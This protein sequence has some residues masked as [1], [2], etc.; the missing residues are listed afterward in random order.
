MI[1]NEANT[2]WTLQNC[3]L[4]EKVYDNSVFWTNHTLD[5]IGLDSLIWGTANRGPWPPNT[6]V[7]EQKACTATFMYDLW[8]DHTKGYEKWF[9]A[10]EHDTV[11]SVCRLLWEAEHRPLLPLFHQVVEALPSYLSHVWDFPCA[12]NWEEG[13]QSRASVSRW[14][15][16]LSEANDI[17][18]LFW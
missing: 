6:T 15:G 4:F 2:C 5:Y 18:P 11:A 7:N 16:S 9:S 13:R 12:A 14:C 3:L 8:T 17:L 10:D 1:N